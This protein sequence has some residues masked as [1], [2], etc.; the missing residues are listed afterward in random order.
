MNEAHVPDPMNPFKNDTPLITI[1]FEANAYFRR[2]SARKQ[3]TFVTPVVGE[4]VFVV[5]HLPDGTYVDSGIYRFTEVSEQDPFSI[6]RTVVAELVNQDEAIS[7]NE[8]LMTQYLTLTYGLKL[9]ETITGTFTHQGYH[10]EDGYTDLRQHVIQRMSKW[11]GR[12]QLKEEMEC[13]KIR[14]PFTKTYLDNRLTYRYPSR[15][16]VQKYRRM[17]FSICLALILGMLLC[18]NVVYNA[19][20]LGMFLAYMA[21]WLSFAKRKLEKCNQYGDIILRLYGAYSKMLQDDNNDKKDLRYKA[22]ILAEIARSLPVDRRITEWH[23]FKLNEGIEGLADDATPSVDK[24]KLFTDF[25][26]TVAPTYQGD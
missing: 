23:I 25:I 12:K 15:G 7:N 6:K 10:W 8:S 24:M 17:D 11:N 1:C 22:Q 21:N 18:N 3:A 4:R 2:Y 26:H 16:S 9:D 14:H 13:F 19:L 5:R 20:M